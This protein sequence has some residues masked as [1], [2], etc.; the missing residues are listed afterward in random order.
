MSVGFDFFCPST[1]GPEA[2]VPKLNMRR[3][4]PRN[5]QSIDFFYVFFK[6]FWGLLFG[7]FHI[8][9]PAIQLD[10]GK[11]RSHLKI[12]KSS[13]KSRYYIDDISSS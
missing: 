8:Y 7:V 3:F 11:S 4:P 10:I 1:E 5:K 13:T 9:P 2:R 6:S 12:D